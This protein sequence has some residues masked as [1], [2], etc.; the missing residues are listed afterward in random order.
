M[1]QQHMFKYDAV[2][3]LFVCGT[4]IKSIHYHLILL[5]IIIERKTEALFCADRLCY[6]FKI[7]G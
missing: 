6:D 7:T 4:R 3:F 5:D 1:F 2:D